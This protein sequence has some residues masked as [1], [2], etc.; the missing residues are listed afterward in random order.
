MSLQNR[1]IEWFE[2]RLPLN[3]IL[4]FITSFGI[5]YYPFPL[6]K[7]LRENLKEMAR[8]PVPY[9]SRWPYFLGILIFIQFLFQIFTGFLLLLYYIPSMEKGYE[10]TIFIIRDVPLGYYI[11]NIHRWGSI[12]IIVFI[13]IRLL[14]FI[15]NKIYHPPRELFWVFG[16]LIFLLLCLQYITGTLLP[17]SNTN[18]WEVERILEI[19]KIIPF[20]N[21]I[22]SFL[23]GGFIIDEHMHLR[24][25]ISHIF[26]IPLFLFTLFYL[27]FLSVRKL[28]FFT[29]PRKKEPLY[30]GYF[31][32]ILIISLFLLGVLFTLAVF[33]PSKYTG[34]FNPFKTPS[35]VVLPFFLLPFH[36]MKIK[37]PEILAGIIMLVLTIAFLF[38]PWIDKSKL[39]PL[40]KKPVPLLIFS[41]IFIFLILTGIF[42]F[43]LR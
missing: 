35:Q 14:R 22:F 10:S 12:L 37:L 27:H 38:L 36:F 34:V 2:K 17:M 24:F 16:F 28:G 6:D 25:Y 23:Y 20:I 26:V 21:L 31:Y 15:Y 41:V 13:I 11:L 30:P 5:F 29:L 33:F 43:Y 40:Y 8:K 42:G 1:I 19:I 3:E 39:I 7:P 18:Y 9:Y 4:S 32:D